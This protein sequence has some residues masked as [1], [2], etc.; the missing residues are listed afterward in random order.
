MQS[1]AL[2][3]MT[4]SGLCVMN[5]DSCLAETIEGF[6]NILELSFIIIFSV[7]FVNIKYMSY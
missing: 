7:F 3:Q 1:Q 4:A 2:L 6:N 5:T